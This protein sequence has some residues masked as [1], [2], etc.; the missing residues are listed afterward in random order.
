MMIAID[1]D[2]TLLT[3]AADGNTVV[4]NTNI[5]LLMHAVHELGLATIMVWSGGGKE[6]AEGVV[7]KYGLSHL[8]D[9]CAAKDPRIMPDITID[10]MDY[11][12]S[13]VNLRLPG[14]IAPTP[15]MGLF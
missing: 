10:D 8:V 6:Y 11:D 12:F 2:N 3:V 9:R 13:K 7:R 1:V 4:L 5:V 14:D 15:Y